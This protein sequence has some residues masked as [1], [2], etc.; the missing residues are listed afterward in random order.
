MFEIGNT[1]REARMRRG[2]DIA[3]CES[4]TKIRAKYLRAM[5]EEHFDLLPSPAYVRGFLRT[6][7]EFLD[8][9]GQLVVDEYE[10]RFGGLDH[11]DLDQRRKH[12][13]RRT[14][15]P[16]AGRGTPARGGRRRTEAHLLWAAIGGVMGIA[17]V[18]WLGLGDSSTPPPPLNAGGVP[19]TTSPTAQD[20]ATASP[21]AP[22]LVRI[23]ITGV[24]Q[25]GSY[26]EIRGGGPGGREV[27]R[28]NIGATESKALQ[29]PKAIWLRTGNAEGLEVRVNGKAYPLS[30]GIADFLVTRQGPRTLGG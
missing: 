10:H 14:Q 17:L 25:F 1:L 22:E 8:M 7:A 20:P 23:R 29:V 6:Y 12:A 24:G 2:L 9:D 5:E 26:V 28:G 4:A 18:V 16:G 3:E 11:P 19:L 21:E 15:R 30:G 13:P 27:Y